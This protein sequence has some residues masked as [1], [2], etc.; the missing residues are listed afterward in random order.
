MLLCQSRLRA[1]GT[2]TEDSHVPV[3]IDLCETPEQETDVFYG[4]TDPAVMLQCVLLLHR[5]SLL[6]IKQQGCVMQIPIFSGLCS[7]FARNIY[8]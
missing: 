6:P 7:S 8:L 5:A 4:K 3:E 1:L 2:D